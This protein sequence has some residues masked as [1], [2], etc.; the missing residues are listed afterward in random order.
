MTAWL[1][2][3]RVRAVTVS[4]KAQ[5]VKL[6]YYFVYYYYFFALKPAEV[7]KRKTAALHPHFAYLIF[8]V[9]QK[10]ESQAGLG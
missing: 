3:H 9:W 5:C 1:L 2:L 8:T 10:N 7:W 4:T 6:N